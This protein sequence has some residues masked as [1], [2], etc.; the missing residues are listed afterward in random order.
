MK[1]CT[2][3]ETVGTSTEPSTTTS[4]LAAASFEAIGVKSVTSDGNTVEDSVL[5]PAPWRM[6]W[7]AGICGWVNGSS[8][9]AYAAVFGRWP[10]GSPATHCANVTRLFLIGTET[11]N[12]LCRPEP[13]TAGPPPAPSTNA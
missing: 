6:L 11:S 1:A 3:A 2:N 10:A 12:T 4:A 7:A 8:T 9:V 5:T 13:N